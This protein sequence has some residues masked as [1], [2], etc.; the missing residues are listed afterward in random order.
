MNATTDA[1]SG[2][3]DPQYRLDR[4]IYWRY[5]ATLSALCPQIGRILMLKAA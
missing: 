2:D 5:M 4:P 1:I 3:I